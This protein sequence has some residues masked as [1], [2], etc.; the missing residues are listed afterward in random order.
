MKKTANC[1][2]AQ[3]Y[4]TAEDLKTTVLLISEVI[5]LIQFH[6]IPLEVKNNSMECTK[7]KKSDLKA[8]APTDP[9]DKNF[10][11]K[12]ILPRFF[13][14]F[15]L[16]DVN[17]YL[18]KCETYNTKDFIYL[19]LCIVKQFKIMII[20]KGVSSLYRDVR[21]CPLMHFSDCLNVQCIL[22]SS[23]CQRRSI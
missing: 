13:T 19:H 9:M 8:K 18:E 5:L 3:R 23:Q 16:L 1:P 2:E 4:S 20:Y 6:C 14:A 15:F 17:L 10:P 22:C 11:F 21:N 7:G 12:Q